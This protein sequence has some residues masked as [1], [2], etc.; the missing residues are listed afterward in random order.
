MAGAFGEKVVA[1]V[2][3]G[4]AAV[5]EGPHGA[6]SV[7]DSAYVMYVMYADFWNTT[8]DRGRLR[9]VRRKLP[10]RSALRS[11]PHASSSYTPRGYMVGS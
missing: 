2:A 8:A 1:D 6:V 5:V 11:A 4:P 10:R 3:R 9:R 7:T